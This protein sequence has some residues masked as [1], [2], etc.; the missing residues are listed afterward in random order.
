[1]KTGKIL[2]KIVVVVCL[3]CLVLTAAAQTKRRKPV[4]RTSRASTAATAANAAEIKASAEKVSTQL[5]NVTKFI[6]VLG[7]VAQTIQDVDASAKS[8]RA[9]RTTI[10]T[11]TRNKQSVVTTI[12]NLRA[13]L[14]ALE[15]EFQT[16]PA[17][18]PYLPQIQGI[19][20]IAANAED[21][22]SAGQFVNSGKTL[23]QVVEKLSDTLAAMP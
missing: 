23:L 9:S 21:Q 12:G 2:S 3:L 18:L 5:K 16:K 14:S 6:Y 15:A 13:G 22:A 20:D 19:S 11:N 17:L 10:D 1:M 8:G 4:R 7:G